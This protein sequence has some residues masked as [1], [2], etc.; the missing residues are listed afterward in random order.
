MR[1]VGSKQTSAAFADAAGMSGPR[2]VAGSA[3]APGVFYC[4]EAYL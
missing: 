4:A 2:V 1:S 3:P